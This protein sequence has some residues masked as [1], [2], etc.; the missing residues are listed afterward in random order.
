[1]NVF[2]GDEDLTLY[3]KIFYLP[4]LF[5]WVVRISLQTRNKFL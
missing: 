3:L 4:E 1:M 5:F 2:E